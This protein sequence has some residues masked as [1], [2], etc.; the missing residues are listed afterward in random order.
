MT[1]AL[2][3]WLSG[4][5]TYEDL[6]DAHEATRNDRVLPMYDFTNQLAALEPAP[7]ATHALFG[8]RRHNQV[9]TNAFLSVITGAIPLRDFM[10]NENLDRIVATAKHAEPRGRTGSNMGDP[11]LPCYTAGY[12]LTAALTDL[13]HQIRALRSPAFSHRASGSS[14]PSD[15]CIQA[16]QEYV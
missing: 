12:R 10:S 14:L 16:M 3:T 9:A 11:E 5:G 2:S 7:P 1:E 8:A 13:P 6:M 15:H 4:F